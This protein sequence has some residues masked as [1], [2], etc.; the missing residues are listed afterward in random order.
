MT[1]EQERKRNYLSKAYHIAKRIDYLESVKNKKKF[2]SFVQYE[3]DG[4]QHIGG[5][6]REEAR[7]IQVLEC[8]EK[9]LAECKKLKTAVYEIRDAIDSVEDIELKNLLTYRYLRCMSM[10][11]IAEEFHCDESTI[12]RKH[13]NALDKI[14]LECTL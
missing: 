12:K 8:D 10:R 5:Y 1:D 14:E 11:Q 3:S 6:N 9:I 7:I 2:S 13:K 4:S